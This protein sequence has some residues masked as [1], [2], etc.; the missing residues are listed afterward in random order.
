MGL[1]TDLGAEVRGAARVLQIGEGFG[2]WASDLGETFTRLD[3]RYQQFYG[4]AHR[5]YQTRPSI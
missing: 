1:A 5:C 3:D 2:E 4:G